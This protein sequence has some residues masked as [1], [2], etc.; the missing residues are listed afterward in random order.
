VIAAISPAEPTRTNTLKISTMCQSFGSSRKALSLILRLSAFLLSI[1]L[2]FSISCKKELSWENSATNQPPIAIAG[3]GSQTFTKFYK[4][5]D[6]SITKGFYSRFLK[7]IR[8]F[9]SIKFEHF[10]KKVDQSFR[11]F[12]WM[13]NAIFLLKFIISIMLGQKIHSER[14]KS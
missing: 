9:A 4:S 8:W 11:P 6:G 5:E 14:I 1:V 3:T 10:S 7:H 2:V 12:A 13:L